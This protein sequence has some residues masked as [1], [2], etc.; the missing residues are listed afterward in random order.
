MPI[1]PAPRGG[2]LK[3]VVIGLGVVVLVVVLG[4][5]LLLPWIAGVLAQRSIPVQLASGPGT[6]TISDARFS[7]GGPQRVGSVTLTDGQG[8][9]MA[10]LS[11]ETPSSLLRLAQAGMSMGD[12]GTVALSGVIDVREEQIAATP[13]QAAPPA[14]PTAPGQPSTPGGSGPAQP[15]E[16]P[17]SLRA[18]VEMRGVDISY[19]PRAASGL[20]RVTIDDL[21]ARAEVSGAGTATLKVTAASPAIDVDG[22]ARNFVDGAGRLDLAA[23]ELALAASISAP[24]EL[25]EGIVRA[26]MKGA[27]GSATSAAGIAPTEVSLGVVARN[28]R[29]TLADAA[30]PARLSSPVPQAV[31]ASMAGDASTLTITSTPSIT[32]T[33]DVLDVPLPR[34][35]SALDLRGARLQVTL[36]TSAIEGRVAPAGQQAQAFVVE[37]ARFVLDV[38][39]AAQTVTLR[40][41]ARGSLDGRDAGALDVDIALAGLLDAAGAPASG[42][43]ARMQGAVRLSDVPTALA[44]PFLA[45][46]GVDAVEVIGS[47]L[48]AEI[49]ARTRE[50]D[51]AAAPSASAGSAGTVA[52]PPTDVRADISSNHARVMLSAFVSQTELLIPEDGLTVRLDRA[53][54]AIRPFVKDGPI[55]LSGDGPMELVVSDLRAP[56]ISGGLPDLSGLLADVRLGLSNLTV[57]EG[58]GTRPLELTRLNTHVLVSGV[59]APRVELDQAAR[60]GESEITA[61]GTFELP[62]LIARRE[63]S[64][65]F[66]EFTPARV[67]PFGTLTVA[68]VPSDLMGYVPADL[69]GAVAR[70]IGPSFDLTIDGKVEGERA[71]VVTLDLTSDGATA[72][73]GFALDGQ[74]V[75]TTEQGF[76]ATLASPGVLVGEMLR[77]RADSPLTDVRWESPLTL[78]LSGLSAQLP[79]GGAAFP[80][81]QLAAALRVQTGTV[82]MGVRAPTGQQRL[83]ARSVDMAASLTPAAGA[84]FTLDSTGEFGGEQ[85]SLKGDMALGKI[86]GPGGVDLAGLTPKGSITAASLPAALLAIFDPANGPIAREALGDRF[87]L[88]LTAPAPASAEG[89]VTGPRSAGLTLRGDSL[90]AM[91]TAA[92]DNQT[93]RVGQA[94]VAMTLT[95]GLVSAAVRQYA[96]GMDPSPRLARPA[97]IALTVFPTSVNLDAAGKPDMNTLAPVRAMLR[98]ADDII[99]LDAPGVGGEPLSAGVRGLEAAVAYYHSNMVQSE[100]SLKAELFDAQE[101]TAAIARLDVLTSLAAVPPPTFEATVADVDTVRLERLLKRPGLASELIGATASVEARGSIP[102]PGVQN[103]V[104]TIVSPRLNTVLNA[105]RTRE[106]VALTAPADVSLQIP[107]VWA[108]RYLLAPKE[109]ARSAPPQFTDPLDLRVRLNR[110]SVANPGPPL[111]PGVFALDASASVPSVRL[112]TADGRA[113]AINDFTAAARSDA[114]GGALAFELATPRIGVGD[115][116]ATDSISV[117]GQVTGL[118]DAAG[119][120]STQTAAVTADAN[121]SVPT[122]VLDTLGGQ[123]GMLVDL[124]GNRTTLKAQARQLSMR[125]GELSASL[126]TD[127][128]VADVKGRVENG[129]FFTDGRTIL[130]LS[131]ITPELS[132]RYVETAIPLLSRMEKTRDDDPA[133]IEAEGLT[134]PLDGDTRKLNGLAT[135]DLGTVQFD[136]S[137]FFGEIVKIAGGKKGGRLG[138]RIEPFELVAREGVVSYEKFTLPLGEFTAQTQGKVDLNTR[139]MD[140]LVYLPLYALAEEVGGA[141]SNVPGLDRLAQIPLR[142]HGPIEK[143]KTD[144]DVERA[145]RENLRDAVKEVIPKD[146]TKPVDDLLKDIFRGG[147]KEERRK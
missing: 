21:N 84:A 33:I 134:I 89:A 78:T 65:P 127:N 10:D 35:G 46:T 43:P 136:T 55:K 121:G 74:S 110:F 93:V 51:A 126:N 142:I 118:A 139:R 81:D 19:T 114:A 4:G 27:Q 115:A 9:K 56:L 77:A 99:V 62:G 20:Q 111:K 40:G 87:D 133:R 45:A 100:A 95:P 128:A 125:G 61:R 71:A 47:T 90:S 85:F 32:G 17:G 103:I 70:G 117:K 60:S 119:N 23:S 11:V 22:Q 12:F 69:R 146:V 106:A 83:T 107:A 101:P 130:E 28:G 14:P 5:A 122:I 109:G 80:M 72:R 108:N 131:R 30:R 37:P 52:I 25:V 68:G 75:R 63:G 104:A 91:A 13:G 88:A 59:E 105:Q 54:R 73:G 64:W 120:V 135:V 50:G 41:G 3:K 6:L 112:R 129:T 145:V 92:L 36:A 34:A 82:E 79:S 66:V 38:P 137:S 18:V 31:L 143:P 102:T 58:V 141:L 67:R 76:V 7:W 124:L 48:S 53:G 144:V 97:S 116:G 16:I 86:L 113:I 123:D 29:L 15:I 1:N 140:L 94:E 24:G 2:A 49:T 39:D 26:L 44:Q 96:P 98:G 147:R 138:E 132:S 42:L 8:A 57:E